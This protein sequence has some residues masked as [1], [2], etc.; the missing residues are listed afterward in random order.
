VVELFRHTLSRSGALPTLIEWDNNVPD[1]ATLQAEA[2]R[3]DA[4][5]NEAAEKSC[6]NRA[7]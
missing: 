7:A 3:V 6:A 5:L 4:M 2:T 1:F